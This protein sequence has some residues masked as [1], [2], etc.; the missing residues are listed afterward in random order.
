MPDK[1]LLSLVGAGPGDPE[2]ITVKGTRT[3]AD[4]DLILYDALVNNQLLDINPAAEKHSVGKRKGQH[5]YSQSEINKLIVENIQK[6]KHVVRLKGGD[7]SVFARAAEEIEYAS[8]FGLQ[9][10][11][12]PGIS[13]YS[14]IAAQHQIP[15]TRRCEFESIWITTGH[16]CKGKISDDLKYAA[17]S[18]ATI[19][20]LMGM[21]KIKDIQTEL[22]KHKPKDY[23]A[24]IVQNG[25]L[26]NEKHFVTSLGT[27]VEDVIKNDLQ[28]P[29]LIIVGH[30]VI[31]QVCKLLATSSV[32]ELL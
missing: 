14:G 21:T 16:T 18:S 15:L 11:V 9:T 28:S 31:D 3:I 6:G 24:A 7:V 20:I 27:L 2:L 23:P 17:Q 22:L 1:G 12:I 8:L 29:A 26:P 10:Q 19:V 32:P 25:T 5:T 30:A 13:S 4:A